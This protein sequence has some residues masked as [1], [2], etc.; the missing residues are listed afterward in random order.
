ME[1]FTRDGAVVKVAIVQA[2]PILYDKPAA[3]EKIVT[4]TRQAAAEGAKLILFPESFIPGYP[5]ELDFDRCKGVNTSEIRLRYKRFFDNSVYEGSMELQPIA[6]VAAETKTYLAVGV[7]EIERTELY[8]SV[9][10]WGPDGNFLGK[11]RKLRPSGFEQLVWSKGDGTNLTVLQTAIGSVGA[12]ICWENYMPL[13]RAALYAKGVDIYLAP[14]ADSSAHWQCTL[15]HIALEGRCFVLCCNHYFPQSSEGAEGRPKYGGGSA[16]ID[17]YGEYLA[18]PLFGQEGVLYAQL[19][20]TKAREVRYEF[21]P[22]SP[23][24][25]SEFMKFSGTKRQCE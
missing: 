16:I 7:T 20:L 11:H 23:Y 12:A 3:V 24:T 14:A 17:P 18:G 5:Q 1:T 13:L 4:F 8:C 22:I 21:D 19:D 10:F 25:R 2:T 15:Q 6:D 9:F